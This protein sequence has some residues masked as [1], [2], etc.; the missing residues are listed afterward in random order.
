[1][2]MNRQISE[3]KIYNLLR[4][5]RES[6]IELVEQLQLIKRP[7]EDYILDKFQNET[8]PLRDQNLFV[9]SALYEEARKETKSCTAVCGLYLV[10]G[11]NCICHP[12]RSLYLS[13]L[14]LS[15]SHN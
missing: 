5:C 2:H 9:H 7:G 4:D 15:W 1:M 8:E 14:G 12:L 3:G 10:A 13:T 6:L 11:L